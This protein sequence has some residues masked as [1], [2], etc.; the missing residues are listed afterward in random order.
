MVII[1]DFV[2]G[3][4]AFISRVAIAQIPSTPAPIRAMSRPPPP[5]KDFRHAYEGAESSVYGPDLSI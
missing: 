1:K 5:S 2:N 4:A 3:H